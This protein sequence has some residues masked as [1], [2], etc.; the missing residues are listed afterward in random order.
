MN[1]IIE[2]PLSGGTGGIGTYQVRRRWRISRT[3]VITWGA[4]L[5]AFWLPIILALWVFK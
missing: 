3:T 4:L 5:V 2:R 1:L